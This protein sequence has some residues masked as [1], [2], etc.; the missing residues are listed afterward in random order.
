MLSSLPKYPSNSHSMQKRMPLSIRDIHAEGDISEEKDTVYPSVWIVN[1]LSDC[2][3]NS[4]SALISRRPLSKK[5]KDAA[6][7]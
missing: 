4:P 1:S 3:V 6:T 7:L 2:H 5:Q